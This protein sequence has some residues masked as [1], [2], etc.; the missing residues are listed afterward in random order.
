[1]R[2][3]AAGG[4]CRDLDGWCPYDIAPTSEASHGAINVIFR[5]PPFGGTRRESTDT[6]VDSW[7][8]RGKRGSAHLSKCRRNG[9][10]RP[11]SNDY[12]KPS[13]TTGRADRPSG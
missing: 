5:P 9:R 13:A 10:R 7:S 8:I 12:G 4:S 2:P 6:A 1:M 11:G 3:T